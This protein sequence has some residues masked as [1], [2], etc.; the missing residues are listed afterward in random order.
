MRTDKNAAK[1]KNSANYGIYY[2]NNLKIIIS[3]RQLTSLLIIY[4][5]L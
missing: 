5:G 3:T 2:K 1:Y 4:L